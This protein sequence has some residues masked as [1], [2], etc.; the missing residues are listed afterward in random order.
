GR[1]ALRWDH[2]AYPMVMV[3]DPD[4]GEVLSFARGGEV[5]LLTAKTK[6]DLLLSNGVTSNRR[7]VRVAP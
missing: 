3:R 2:R 5:Q 7:R 6:V 1:V 4:T